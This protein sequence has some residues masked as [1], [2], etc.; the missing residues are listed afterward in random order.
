MK[1]LLLNNLPLEFLHLKF[2]GLNSILLNFIVLSIVIL[3]L[4]LDI[5]NSQ[6]NKQNNSLPQKEGIF[7][8]SDKDSVLIGDFVN[9]EI[10][11]AYPQNGKFNFDILKDSL[12]KNL[13]K[14][15][16]I[17]ISKIDTIISNKNSNLQIQKANYVVSSYEVG[18]Q[19]IKSF[20]NYYTTKN[21]IGTEDTSYISSN[22]LYIT[23]MG[24]GADTT[25]AFKD[26]KPPIEVE[27]DYTD[28]IL[29][30]IFLIFL[31]DFL[32]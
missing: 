28:Y 29:W 25:K 15:E 9:L 4:S 1:K 19:N 30:A 32:Y 10:V 23:F 24:V 7:I 22:N 26:I 31:G 13:N 21:S 18:V 11:A 27:F 2:K 14:Y 8:K 17:S 12:K 3:F 5:I 20:Y 16:I 6:T